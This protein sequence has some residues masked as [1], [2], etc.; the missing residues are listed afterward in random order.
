[1][2]LL[3]LPL[4]SVPNTGLWKLLGASWRDGSALHNTLDVNTYQR[5]P[6]P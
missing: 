5:L 6:L 1:M 2:L 4:A 3:V